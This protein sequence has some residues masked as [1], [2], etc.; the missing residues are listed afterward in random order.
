MP[1]PLDKAHYADC[2]EIFDRAMASTRG[3]QRK[4]Q[5]KESANIF[6]QRLHKARALDRELSRRVYQATTDH[7]L[8]GS[9]QYS[10]IVCRLIYDEKRDIWL[11]RLE[12]NEIDPSDIEDLEVVIE[13]REKEQLLDD[14]NAITDWYGFI[15]AGKE[16]VKLGR[17]SFEEVKG[18]AATFPPDC[19]FQEDWETD[20]NNT[21]ERRG[22]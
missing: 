11:C 3:V 22:E 7:P 9:S 2:Y 5:D 17:L 8:W 16:N 15:K 4:F 1:L 13:S 12:K 10:V 21:V 20:E 14:L 18:I 19:N 6:R